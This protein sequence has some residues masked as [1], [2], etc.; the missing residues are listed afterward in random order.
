MREYSVGTLADMDD[1]LGPDERAHLSALGRTRA[2]DTCALIYRQGEPADRVYLLC[3]GEVKSILTNR[4]G[5]DCLLRL[6]LANSLLGLSALASTPRRDASAV[7]S[8]P[9]TL[10]EIDA[11]A[12]QHAMSASPVLAARVVRLLVDRMSDFHHR[13]GDFLSLSV[14]QRVAQTLLSLARHDPLT[15]S[16]SSGATVRMT[17][18]DLA[19]LL[20]ARRPTV[21]SALARLEHAG[22]IARTGR[23]ITLVDAKGLARMIDDPRA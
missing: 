11:A 13:V 19:G 22:L 12:F 21:T 18:E 9:A 4:S 5:E 1:S 14:E 3:D 23:E 6:H 17:H 15:A 7:A 2:C 20:S 10:I 8:S 16:P